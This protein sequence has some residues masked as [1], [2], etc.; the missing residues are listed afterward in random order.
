M[1]SIG[2]FDYI[3]FSI[4]LGGGKKECT[5]AIKLV[6]ATKILNKA[7]LFRFW[8]IDAPKYETFMDITQTFTSNKCNSMHIQHL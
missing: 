3:R 5:P 4:I 7:L 1:L 6:G 8:I 2:N